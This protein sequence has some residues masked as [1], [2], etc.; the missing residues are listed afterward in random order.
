[1]TTGPNEIMRPIHD[2]MPVIIGARDWT[3]W[4]DTQCEGDD[5]MS[6]LLAPFAA[7]E[8]EAWPVSRRVSSAREEGM[9]LIERLTESP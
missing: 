4:L 1:M 6:I 2:R 3:T 7:D 9:D 8:M 5:S